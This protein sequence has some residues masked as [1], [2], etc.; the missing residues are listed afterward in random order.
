M[1]KIL[2]VV[3]DGLGDEPIPEFNNQTPL[4]AADTPYMDSLAKQGILGLADSNFSGALP[5]S[6][7][8]HFQ[9]FGY[10]P[11][12]L[13][14]KRGMVTAAGSGIEVQPGD[15]ALRANFAYVKDGEAVAHHVALVFDGSRKLQ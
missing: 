12:E 14:L 15:V 1:K 3:L 2:L 13:G 7:E 4:A 9:L 10:D 8:G 6:E 11:I 5:T